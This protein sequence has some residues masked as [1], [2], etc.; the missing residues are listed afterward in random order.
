MS[1][2]PA[3]DLRVRRSRASLQ[4]ALIQLMKEKPFGEIQ[5]AEI[6][7][8]AGVSRPT[9]YL[10]YRSK[11]ELLMS[12]V[13]VVFEEFYGEWSTAVAAG[14]F[15]RKEFSIRMFRYWERHAE[16]MRLVIQADI[17]HALRERLKE[18]F[19]LATSELAVRRGKPSAYLKSKDLIVDFISGGAHA[20]LTQ[21]IARGMPYSAEQMGR[22]FYELT[23]PCESAGIE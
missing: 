9:F 15:D 22:L 21:W 7:D 10:H 2:Q 6:A 12:R 11:E 23:V 4:D 3:M 20:L 19:S 18:Y 1:V 17:H 8:R 5:I 16:T 13:D 14:T